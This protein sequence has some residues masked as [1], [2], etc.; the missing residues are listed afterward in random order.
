MFVAV[1]TDERMMTLYVVIIIGV[2]VGVVVTTLVALVFYWKL[3][4]DR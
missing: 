2:S 3:R 1:S 4:T